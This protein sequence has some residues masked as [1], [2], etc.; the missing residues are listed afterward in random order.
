MS[1]AL[2][3]HSQVAVFRITLDDLNIGVGEHL[4][5]EFAVVLLVEHYPGDAGLNDH[6]GAELAWERSCVDCRSNGSWPSC[7]DDGRL[8]RVEAHTLV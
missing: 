6:L 7:F 1:M 5:R 3:K 8:L 2:L 4:L